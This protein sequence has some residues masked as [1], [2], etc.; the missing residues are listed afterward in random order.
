MQINGCDCR[1]P[2]LTDQQFGRPCHVSI[3][4]SNYAKIKRLIWSITHFIYISF[5]VQSWNFC[6]EVAITGWINLRSALPAQYIKSSDFFFFCFWINL[7]KFRFFH[8]VHN[9]RDISTVLTVCTPERGWRT[10][11]ELLVSPLGLSSWHS[12]GRLAT[13]LGFFFN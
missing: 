6:Y 1:P 5:E 8:N 10:K 4:L 3:K 9:L 7:W 12:Q 2:S 11:N 13:H